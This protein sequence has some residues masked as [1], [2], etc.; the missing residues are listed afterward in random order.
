[1]DN[2][3]ELLLAVELPKRVS[4]MTDEEVGRLVDAI[5]DLAKDRLAQ[6]MDER[7]G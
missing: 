4:E 1:M 7:D 6:A 2:Q 5:Y 3:R